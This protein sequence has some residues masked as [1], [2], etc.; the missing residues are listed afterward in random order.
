MSE[1]MYAEITGDV[2]GCAMEVHRVLGCGFQEYI[3][4]RALSIEL[5]KRKF[6]SLNSLK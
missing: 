6:N 4:Q 1:L 5:A 2:I 3:Y